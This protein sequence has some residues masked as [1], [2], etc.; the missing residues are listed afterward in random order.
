MQIHRQTLFAGNLLDVVHV[1]ART[2]SEQIGEL[3]QQSSSVVVFPLAGIFACN[4]GPRKHAIATP[5]HAMCLAPARPYR[6]SF[7]GALGD[8]CLA[9]R[10]SSSDRTRV[11]PKETHDAFARMVSRI[12]PPKV[13]LERALFWRTLRRGEYDPLDIEEAAIALLTAAVDERGDGSIKI[14]DS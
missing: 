4:D 14:R 10:I 12:L 6:L 9:I 7:P 8:E 3:E 5:L 13:L 11:L 1:I 2:T